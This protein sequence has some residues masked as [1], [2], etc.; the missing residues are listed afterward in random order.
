M[1]IYKSHWPSATPSNVRHPSLQ[2]TPLPPHPILTFFSPL[3][4]GVFDFLFTNNP[5]YTPSRAAIID[6]AT[7]VQTTYAELKEESLRFSDGLRRIARLSSDDTILIFSPN[8]SLYPIISLAAV[9][10]SITIST[11]N[12]SYTPHELA[13]QLSEA[14]AVLMLVGSDLIDV[15]V[16]AAKEVGMSEDRIYVLPGVD[17]TVAAKGLRSYLEL[18]GEV[19]KPVAIRETELKTRAAFLPFSSGTTSKPKGVEISHSNLTSACRQLQSIPEL[20][21][22]SEV[23]MGVLPLYHIYG[24]VVVM[25]VT[26]ATGGTVVLLPKFDLA[27]YCSAVQKY[28]ATVRPHFAHP[29]TSFHSNN[30]DLQ[31]SFIVPPI[32][33]GLAKHPSVPSYDLSSIRFILS[34]AAPLSADLQ[35]LLASRLGKTAV[36]QGYGMTETTSVALLPDL[37]DLGPFGNCGKLLPGMDA[38]LVDE[39]LKDVKEGEAGELLI[40]GPNIMIKYHKNDEATARTIDKDGWMMTGDVCVRSATGHYTIVDRRKEFMKYKGFQV[41]PS[42]LEG[43]LLSCPMVA[44]AAVIGVWSEEQATELPRAYVV[45]DA[46][47]IN[48]KDVCLAIQNFVKGKVAPHKRLRGGVITMDVIPK[49][50]S[51]KILRKDLR[52]LAAQ[53]TTTA[54]KL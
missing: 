2:R 33:L 54:A 14:S 36:I 4:D 3:Q 39:E 11:A 24:L 10:S 5:T 28:R 48:T 41:I 16:A 32:A 38:R 26:F 23:V 29:Q 44:D 20:Y 25:A 43:I 19:V 8:S 53:E 34:G 42:E 17:G 47:H 12:S 7:G 51:G 27:A 30:F 35:S 13:H 45:I 18:R 49:S 31:I 9:A 6:A 50:P 52:V 15:A 40:R 21:H 37:G 22:T 46:A 1:T